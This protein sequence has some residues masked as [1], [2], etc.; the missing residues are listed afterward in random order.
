MVHQAIKQVLPVISKES[1][2]AEWFIEAGWFI[3]P[4]KGFY[5]NSVPGFNSVDLCWPLEGQPGG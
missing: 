3:W 1:L 5:R 2:V 4:C